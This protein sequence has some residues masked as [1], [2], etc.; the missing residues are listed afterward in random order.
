MSF[1]QSCKKS[2]IGRV[3]WILLEM[4]LYH[5]IVHPSSERSSAGTL[6]LLPRIV[7]LDNV[8]SFPLQIPLP[9]YPI[10]TLLRMPPD[11]ARP[12]EPGR[13][14]LCA[15]L[16]LARSRLQPITRR[17]PCS[18][19]CA[20]AHAAALPPPLPPCRRPR[21]A[22]PRRRRPAKLA[23]DPLPPQR[24]FSALPIANPCSAPRRKDR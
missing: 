18:H 22:A 3:F 13:G 14:V 9:A 17:R 1:F 10:R 5:R 6:R 24:R 4:L 20:V 11:N 12:R 15:A 7:D 2:W 21:E 19:D 16:P 23:C 8:Y